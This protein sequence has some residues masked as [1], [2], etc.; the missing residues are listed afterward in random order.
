M[1]NNLPNETNEARK[2]TGP[3][4]TAQ[5]CQATDSEQ[6]RRRPLHNPTA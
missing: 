5:I 2:P 3:V 6:D 1:L 4:Y